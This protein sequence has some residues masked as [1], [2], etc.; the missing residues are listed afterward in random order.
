MPLDLKQI[1][2]A[3]GLP[4]DGERPFALKK[5]QN[6]LLV[7]LRNHWNARGTDRVAAA[8]AL[9]TGKD[10]GKTCN[11]IDQLLNGETFRQYWFDRLV[12]Y[13]EIP[14]SEVSAARLE[15]DAWRTQCWVYRIRRKRLHAFA[16][17][18]P[19][20]YAMPQPDWRP[21]LLGITGDG[22]LYDSIPEEVLGTMES[23]EIEAIL[24]WMRAG[25]ATK[26]RPGIC[27]G[28]LLHLK[29][30]DVR[31]HTHDG[32]LVA[33]GDAAEPPPQGFKEFYFGW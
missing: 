9:T 7:L 23:P 15:L 19:Y 4:A 33:T 30:E 17:R 20:I 3:S 1:L 11:R 32:T 24:G 14:A 2:A 26:F 5:S 6:S 8:K 13:L 29:P 12:E 31:F 21:S 28:F 22:Y 25:I 18:G 16:K 27:A 10:V